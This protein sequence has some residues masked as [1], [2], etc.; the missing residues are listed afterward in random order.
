LAAPAGLQKLFARDATGLTKQLSALDSLAI[1]LSS[2]GPLF[3]FNVIVFLPSLYPQANL[4]V[5][6]LLGLVIMLPVAGV[7][8]LMSIAMPRAGG[9]YV[10]VSR[11]LHPSIGFVSNFALSL[12]SL[13]TIGIGTPTIVQWA[14]AE[15]FY[16]FGILYN[17]Q[18]YLNIATSLQNSTT[19]FEWSAAL[20]IV[21][22]LIV[23]FSS[24]F[25][26]AVLKYW[27]IAAMV[28]GVVFVATVALAGSGAFASNFDR[29]SGSNY[30]SVIAAGQSAGSYAGIPPAISS[31]TLYASA[32]SGALGFL[33][34][35]NPVYVAGEVKQAR[36][37]MITAQL[38]ALIIFAVFAFAVSAAEYFGEGPSFANAM[39][40]LWISGSSHFPYVAA[41]L[42]SGM[43]VFWTQN[44]LLI[45]TFNMGYALT[46]ELFNIATLFV[47]ARN[48][49]AWSFDK[50]MPTAFASVNGRTHTPIKATVVMTAVAIVYVYISVFQ[51]GILASYFSYS[52]A[53]TFL[54][55]IIVAVAAIVYPYR[56]KDIFA[57]AD[58][59]SSRM[60]GGI[61]LVTLFG[62]LT[63]VSSVIIVYSV[64]APILTATFPTVLVEG[65]IPSFIIG[66][67]LFAVAW[68]VRKSQGLDL[69][70]LQREI[71]P[72]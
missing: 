69:G 4:L 21:A 15:M 67:V 47:F 41:P 57:K 37:S 58:G 2:M 36:R 63:L 68:V 33:G 23:I 26:A 20:I 5:T 25:S 22:G 16:D 48:L 39:A 24:R 59:I 27:T 44:P 38:G 11:V 30:D 40:T 52:V 6:P 64:V 60:M 9:D 65:I 7:Y 55:T 1:A 32:A 42:A 61:P 10:W 14:S 45:G 31:A 72:E 17:N 66:A 12:I 49:F 51:F 28:I 50:V 29:L 18:S 46:I 13:A 70:L 34:F 53:G 3:A 71:P 56:R 54:A 62:L 8:I 35:Y 19:I 43:S